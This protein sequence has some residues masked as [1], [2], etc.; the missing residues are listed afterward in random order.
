[1]EIIEHIDHILCCY[2]NRDSSTL[3]WNIHWPLGGPL[4]SI[5]SIYICTLLNLEILYLGIYSKEKYIFLKI[6]GKSIE[7]NVHH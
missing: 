2:A 1:M 7:K 5:V 3:V 4:G 6:H